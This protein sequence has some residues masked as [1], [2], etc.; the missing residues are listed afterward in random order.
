MQVADAAAETNEGAMDIPKSSAV[1]GA[2]MH[3]ARALPDE[4]FRSFAGAVGRQLTAYKLANTLGAG[5][6]YHALES[7]WYPLQAEAFKFLL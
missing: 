6:L 1:D 5:I 2:R 4:S 7:D 3:A